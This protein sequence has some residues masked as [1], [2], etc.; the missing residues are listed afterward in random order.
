MCS[1]L[2]V[3]GAALTFFS[4]SLVGL[5]RH[6][7]WVTHIASIHMQMLLACIFLL[8]MLIFFVMRGPPLHLT[9]VCTELQFIP[10][11]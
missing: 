1:L 2:Y 9:L 7:A 6:I 4:L 3:L 8:G 11:K 10:L 5:Y